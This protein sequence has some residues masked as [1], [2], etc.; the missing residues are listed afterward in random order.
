MV[1]K[2]YGV[3]ESTLQDWRGKGTGPSYSKPTGGYVVYSKESL[4][5][6]YNKYRVITNQD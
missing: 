3:P 4:E 1:S 5:A 6:W 2:I